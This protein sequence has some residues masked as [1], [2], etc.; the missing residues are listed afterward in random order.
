ML[1]RGGGA[2]AALAAGWRSAAASAAAARSQRARARRLALLRVAV[3][4]VA[5]SPGAVA[6][7]RRS[8]RRYLRCHAGAPD[9]GSVVLPRSRGRGARPPLFCGGGSLS[10]RCVVLGGSHSG[11]GACVQSPPGPPA[12]R[13]VCGFG[14]P[15]SPKKRRWLWRR[16]LA[17]A[18]RQR[19]R[20][21]VFKVTTR[22]AVARGLGS[23]RRL[24]GVGWLE[25]GRRRTR[26]RDAIVARSARFSAR[27]LRALGRA[28]LVGT[29][30]RSWFSARSA[31]PVS[32]SIEPSRWCDEE[33]TSAV[34]SLDA[35]RRARHGARVRRR[36]VRRTHDKVGGARSTRRLARGSALVRRRRCRLR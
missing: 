13:V 26:A 35:R 11:L 14:R 30:T 9:A 34:A 10:A 27:L 6:V 4:A 7:V 17:R 33:S 16:R 5:S 2:G 21:C 15:E 36:N 24:L 31:S 8:R 12:T 19:R 22:R 23:R 28:R 25:A 32:A 18:R 29:T 20:L 3:G 1:R